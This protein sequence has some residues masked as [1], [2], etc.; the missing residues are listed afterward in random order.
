[1]LLPQPG[2]IRSLIE[3]QVPD[4]VMSMVDLVAYSE[5]DPIV[6]S[7]ELN[8]GLLMQS[9]EDIRKRTRRGANLLIA[10]GTDNVPYL[11]HALAEGVPREM[12]GD[13]NIIVV[14]SQ[15][16]APA[17]LPVTRNRWTI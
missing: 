13:R 17:D 2:K 14:V 16:H 6:D 11:M 9:V 4:R 3:N 7:A 15:T 5:A 8:V 10:S 12:L 1:M